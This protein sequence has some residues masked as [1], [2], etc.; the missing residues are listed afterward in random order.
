MP[1]GNLLYKLCTAV[2]A[3]RWWD[4]YFI[5]PELV[6]PANFDRS[7]MSSWTRFVNRMPTAVELSQLR[8]G[9][10]LDFVNVSDSAF[11]QAGRPIGVRR[12][13]VKYINRPRGVLSRTYTYNV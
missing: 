11:W 13:L 6:L 2:P 10:T 12:C 9:V 3:S 8:S 5:M 7:T 4:A 1:C